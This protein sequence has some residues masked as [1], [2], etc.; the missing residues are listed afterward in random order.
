MIC[1]RVKDYYCFAAAAA[2]VCSLIGRRLLAPS[3]DFCEVDFGGDDDD[4]D[5]RAAD[6]EAGFWFGLAFGARSAP[7]DT[8]GRAGAAAGR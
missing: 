1:A 5:V 3:K 7:A 4:D 6:D 2:A 8:F